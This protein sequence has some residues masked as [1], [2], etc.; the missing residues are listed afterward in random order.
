MNSQFQK[1]ETKKITRADWQ[2]EGPTYIPT[3]YAEIDAALSNRRLRHGIKDVESDT[4]T[5]FPSDHF[6]ATIKIKIKLSKIRNMQKDESNTWKSPKKPTEEQTARLNEQLRTTM[7][8]NDTTTS[9]PNSI[10]YNPTDHVSDHT[11]RC[12]NAGYA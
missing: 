10:P 1:P 6:P 9:G 8:T 7:T 5:A 4:L 3:R 2:A 12:T 11:H